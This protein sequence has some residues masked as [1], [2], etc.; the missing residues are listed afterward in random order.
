MH[1]YFRPNN[2]MLIYTTD[3]HNEDVFKYLFKELHSDVLFGSV[4]TPGPTIMHT[5]DGVS[6]S[7]INNINI[8]T[9][10]IL[11]EAYRSL[12]LKEQFTPVAIGILPRL[13]NIASLIKNRLDLEFANK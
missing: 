7:A 13:E 10:L 6:R 3:S 8:K 9:L 4:L 11:A 1:S 2:E 5:Y 12:L